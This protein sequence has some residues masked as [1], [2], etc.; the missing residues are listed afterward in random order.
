VTT[1]PI[2]II[3]NN[4]YWWS[5]HP[6]IFSLERWSSERMVTVNI[7][8][9]LL[10]LFLPPWITQLV[11]SKYIFV[12]HLPIPWFKNHPSLEHSPKC[13]IKKVFGAITSNKT[14]ITFSKI[15]KIDYLVM[16]YH[17]LP[18]NVLGMASQL[19]PNELVHAKQVLCTY[20]QNI[21]LQAFKYP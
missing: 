20:Q 21:N 7:I 10:N 3:F 18:M 16:H 14:F 19:W 5:P 1:S 6:I 9:E 4:E 2:E 15:C 12:E 13:M 11:Q 8:D 17:G